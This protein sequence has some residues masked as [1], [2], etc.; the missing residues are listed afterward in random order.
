[1]NHRFEVKDKL[2]LDGEPFQI[3]SGAIH[4]YRIVPEYWRDRL[5]KLK[6]M[7]CNTVETYG[8]GMYMNQE[9]TNSALKGWQILEGLSGQP[10]SWGLW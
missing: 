3:I 9:K 8:P 5:E 2:Y 6:A 4:Y 7:G 1:M 10:E